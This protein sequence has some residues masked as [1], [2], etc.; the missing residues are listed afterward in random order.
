[1]L[2]SFHNTFSYCLEIN[3]EL[4]KYTIKASFHILLRRNN[5]FSITVELFMTNLSHVI[6]DPIILNNT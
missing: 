4:V 5:L 1:M 3:G 2:L 6:L